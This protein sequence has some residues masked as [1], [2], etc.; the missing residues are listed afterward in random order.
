M[1]MD[2]VYFACWSQEETCSLFA[3]TFYVAS[4]AAVSRFVR[5][6]Q[7]QLI[8]LSVNYYGLLRSTL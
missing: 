5:S 2:H 6:S 4:V 3:A 8:N 7:I 1:C